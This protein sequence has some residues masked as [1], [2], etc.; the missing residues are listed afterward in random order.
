MLEVQQLRIG[1]HNVIKCKS[2][3]RRTKVRIKQDKDAES[4]IGHHDV[5]GGRNFLHRVCYFRKYQ[6][7][8]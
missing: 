3:I 5:D 7:T 8:Y 2:T 4:E 1:N 6:D